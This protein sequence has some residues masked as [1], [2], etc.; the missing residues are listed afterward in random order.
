MLIYKYFDKNNYGEISQ[1]VFYEKFEFILY[2][3]IDKLKEDQ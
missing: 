1:D 2:S 3:S